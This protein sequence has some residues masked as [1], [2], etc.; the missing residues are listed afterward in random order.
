MH[1]PGRTASSLNTRCAPSYD[2][3]SLGAWK[4]D[5][6]SK[7]RTRAETPLHV[8]TPIQLPARMSSEKDYAPLGT[9]VIAN[10]DS[11]HVLDTGT[12]RPSSRIDASHVSQAKRRRARPFVACENE[13]LDLR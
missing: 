11:D 1:L 8:K 9:P 5:D 3:K 12:I 6:P 7:S 2:P 4:P 13:S 10:K